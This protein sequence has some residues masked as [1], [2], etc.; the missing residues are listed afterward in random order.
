MAVPSS[1]GE[2][3]PALAPPAGVLEIARRLSDMGRQAW[4]VGGAVRDALLGRHGVDWDIATD[5]RPEEVRRIFRRTVPL[6]IEH[7]TV[8]V[9]AKDGVMYEVTT[10]RRDVETFG[11]HAVVA[12]ADTIDE[13]LAR[14]DFTINALAWDPLTHELRDPYGGAADLRDG[15]LRTVG[16]PAE[17]FAE[18][19]LRVLR[20]LRFAGHYD[21]TID[22]ATWDALVAA[23]PQLTTLSAERIR[24][25]LIKVLAK[26]AG[27]S[28]TLELYERSGALRVL[29]PEVAETVGLVTGDEPEPDAWR[30][31]LRAV[32]AISRTRTLLRI[33][34]FLHGTGYPAART[35]DL[36]GGWRFTGHEVAAGRKA[37]DVMRRLRASNAEVELVRDFVSLQG[38][39]FPPD[40]NDAQV[41]RW[42]VRVGPQRVLDLF[43]LR[44]ALWRAS[45]VAR[46]DRDLVERWRK[47]H[48]VLLAHPP[49]EIRDLAVGGAEL[50][51]LGL[52]PGPEF[53]EILRALLERVLDDPSLNEKETLMRMVSR[54]LE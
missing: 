21:L 34:A 32:D 20:A 10:F 1:A 41:R 12:F 8:G 54:E 51:G 44:I 40:A 18:D 39:L 2:T 42:L 45:P 19:W 30:R 9:L 37:E 6:G 35:R 48:R 38:D 49:L 36:R 26:T 7:G 47:A 11:R 28:V 27:A 24:E 15:V 16:V 5:A 25:E 14:R 22:P 4:A 13:D 53:G 50:R 23:A 43:R 46:G 29:Y 31:A 17:R 52:E 33:A 3:A